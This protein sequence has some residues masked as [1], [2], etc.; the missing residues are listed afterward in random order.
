LIQ[1]QLLFLTLVE[2]DQER[3]VKSWLS[4]VK[5]LNDQ[6]R[7]DILLFWNTLCSITD[8]MA[9]DDFDPDGGSP[10]II[11]QMVIVIPTGAFTQRPDGWSACIGRFV[12]LRWIDEF[13]GKR[14]LQRSSVTKL[15]IVKTLLNA[16]ISVVSRRVYLAATSGVEVSLPGAHK[17]LDI[18][19]LDASNYCITLTTATK[20]LLRC[21]HRLAPKPE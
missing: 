3:G 12:A 19:R 13:G 1:L 2:F 18:Q 14:R 5:N 15:K 11:S 17:I 8:A 10:A 20:Q 7:D 16:I 9:D 4:Y 6:E 21:L